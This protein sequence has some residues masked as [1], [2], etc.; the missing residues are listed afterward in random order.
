MKN[1]KICK[2]SGKLLVSAAV[3]G[4]LGG[5]AATSAPVELSTVQ[6]S[7]NSKFS[8]SNKL[9][10]EYAK[11]ITGNDYGNKLLKVKG[12]VVTRDKVSIFNKRFGYQKIVK[13]IPKNRQVKFYAFAPGKADGVALK[14]GKNKYI[15]AAAA[16]AINNTDFGK[17]QEP[18]VLYAHKQK[19][20][21]VFKVK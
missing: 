13:T 12:Y 16:G 14:V 2:F 20:I 15:L 10:N 5:V 8:F 4:M 3:A 19:G 6:A 9:G 11:K 18:L 17:K 7:K 21:K 1:N